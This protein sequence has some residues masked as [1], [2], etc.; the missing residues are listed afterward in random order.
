MGSLFAK[1]IVM[2][3]LNEVGY[4]AEGNN[5]KFTIYSSELDR[6][7]YWNGMDAKNGRANWCSIFYNWICYANTRN[8]NG[9]IEANKW[10]AH[11]FLFEPDDR[12]NLAA[13]C[14]YA[15]DYY[16]RNNAWTTNPERGDQA[17]FR[18]YAHT[19]VVVDWDNEG[20]YTVEG[21]VDGGRV[22]K[23]YYRYSE[24]GGSGCV[25]GFG[26]PRFDGW[27][28]KPNNDS[29]D[30]SKPQPQT[31]T[32]SIKITTENPDAVREALKG[33]VITIE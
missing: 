18:N 31:V 12:E 17:F 30:N 1:D 24:I 2:T 13:G 19:G 4:E 32:L 20:F 5:K 10:D 11:Y 25:D 22:E 8:E 27:E 14:G 9:E 28:Y 3:A 33:A 7:D 23:R 16:Q 6:C 29:N 26:R 21:N 15:A